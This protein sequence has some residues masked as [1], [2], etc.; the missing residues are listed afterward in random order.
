L[1]TILKRK[2]PAAYHVSLSAVKNTHFAK[3]GMAI[4]SDSN[5]AKAAQEDF[6]L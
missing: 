4:R 6:C 1:R 5:P 2:N 3:S